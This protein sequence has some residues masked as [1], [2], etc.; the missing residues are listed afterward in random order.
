MDPDSLKRLQPFDGASD[1]ASGVAVLLEIARAMN[2]QPPPIGVDIVFF[3]AEDLGR[4]RHDD[5]WCLGSRHFAR[6]LPVRYD[7]VI[8]V[9]LVGD[10]DLTLYREGYSYRSAR[11]L[12]D[13]I[14]KIAEE[15][16]EVAFHDALDRA[17]IDDHVPF[18]MRG[19][20]AVDIIDFRYPYWHTADD[21][22]DKC[23]P[24]SLGSVGRVVL[25]LIYHE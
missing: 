11:S 14:W 13:R 22:A 25:H 2:S 5:E 17:I 24:A 9:D 23:S 21:T 3:D 19:L 7:W 16:G 20:P 18:L 4:Y 1:G 8:V 6:H 15:L 10:R 12:Q